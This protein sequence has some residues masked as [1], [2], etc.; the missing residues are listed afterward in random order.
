[1]VCKPKGD[2]R[3]EPSEP[4]VAVAACVGRIMPATN[5]DKR[6]PMA[7]AMDRAFE[8][9]SIALTMSLPAFLGHLADDKFGTSP[10]LVV[11][12]AVLGLTAG[13]YQLL[14]FVGGDKK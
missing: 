9:I 11:V 13:M 14:R 7:V 8:I 2:E 12:V 1:M 5:G 6:P 3:P 4:V 10:W